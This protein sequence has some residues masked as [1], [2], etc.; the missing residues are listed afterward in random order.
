VPGAEGGYV[1]VS[2]AIKKTPKDAPRPGAFRKTGETAEAA[3]PEV[4][5]ETAAEPAPTVESTDEGVE[6]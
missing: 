5:A 1:R 3:P 2:D 6:G 4:H